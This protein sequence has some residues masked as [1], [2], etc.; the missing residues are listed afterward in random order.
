MTGVCTPFLAFEFRCSDLQW[1][2]EKSMLRSTCI[3]ASYV[4]EIYSFYPWFL[5]RRPA[6]EVISVE[7][8]TTMRAPMWRPCLLRRDTGYS[9]EVLRRY[10]RAAPAGT[11][12]VESGG[13][14]VLMRR[15]ERSPLP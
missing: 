3:L 6:D 1:K 2:L 9:H 7:M 15:M 4:F 5:S 14:A 11:S 10:T 8:R 13:A 12:G